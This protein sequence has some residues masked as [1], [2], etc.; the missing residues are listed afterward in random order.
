LLAGLVALSA[1]AVFGVFSV[2]HQEIE[3]R[4][5]DVAK[6]AVRRAALTALRPP[7]L[8]RLRQAPEA[9]PGLFLHCRAELRQHLGPAFAHL[10]EREQ[11][12]AFSTV[13]AHSLAPWGSDSVCCRFP[14]L[15]RERTL[16]CG[17]YGLLVHYL[18]QRFSAGPRDSVRLRFVGWDGH[19]VGNHQMLFLDR[20]DGS[21]SLLLDPTIGLVADADFD[22]VASGRPIPPGRL[23]L[24]QVRDELEDFTCLVVDALVGGR[25][26]PSDLLYY[27]DG[28]D[29]LMQHYGRAQ[30]WPTPGACAWRDRCLKA[31]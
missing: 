2:C 29:R 20:L 28:F 3:P 31:P 10:T 12:Y 6:A 24:F 15:L 16:N 26:R 5:A 1:T 23:V 9:L 14:D 27:F 17:N 25:I 7:V 11:Q 30:D 22:T 13:V 19:A 18:A 8:D 21:H 4:P